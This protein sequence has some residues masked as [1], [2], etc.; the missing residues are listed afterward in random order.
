MLYQRLGRDPLDEEHFRTAIDLRPE[1]PY[2]LNAY[3][4]SLCHWDRFT[5]A[6][7]RYRQALANPRYATPW[8]AMANLGTY[9]RQS[10]NLRTAEICFRR[11]LSANP[12]FGAAIATLADLDYSRGRYRSAK[13]RLDRYL[14]MV[15]PTPRVLLLAVRIDHKLG[16]RAPPAAY[17]DML[18]CAI[19]V[20]RKLSG[21]KG[22]RA[23]E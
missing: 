10:G 4:S 3:A 8:L 19:P 15:Q 13:D 16:S 6:R 11:T 22:S 18:A 12:R 5:S 21:C 9:T 1:D 17:A 14:R 7:L 2:V 23:H 20:H